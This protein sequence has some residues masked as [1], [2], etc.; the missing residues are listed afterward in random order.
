MVD[1]EDYLERKLTNIS[2]S[3]LGI[4]FQ[5][6]ENNKWSIKPNMIDCIVKKLQDSGATAV[7]VKKTEF[8][9][10]GTVYIFEF[11]PKYEKSARQ[12][13]LL[14]YD[15]VPT[16]EVDLGEVEVSLQE[17][18]RGEDIKNVIKSR[19]DTYEHAIR[20]CVKP[21]ISMMRQPEAPFQEPAPVPIR[22]PKEDS[23]MNELV[24]G[25]KKMGVGGRKKSRRQKK[26]RTTRRKVM[27]F[28]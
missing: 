19:L 28:S 24:E 17:K 22:K 2:I 4:S 20:Q 12:S 15:G 21:G 7:R 23:S 3:S 6:M 14:G 27:N 8:K 5:D 1:T 11:S 9:G 13:F 18:E 10:Q 25:M 16:I 26:K